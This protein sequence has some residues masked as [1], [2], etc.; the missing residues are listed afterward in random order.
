MTRT[1]SGRST[2]CRD[3]GS[4]EMNLGIL[5]NDNV[6]LGSSIRQNISSPVQIPFLTGILSDHRSALSRSLLRERRRRLCT[7]LWE[8]STRTESSTGIVFMCWG[9]QTGKSSYPWGQ[10]QNTL[11]NCRTTF[12]FMSPWSQIVL[13]HHGRVRHSLRDE[14]CVGK[15]WF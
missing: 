9:R 6:N 11:T 12:R 15:F 4:R 13:S 8:R 1:R 14:F 3:Q 5:Q 2:V 10:I 7:S